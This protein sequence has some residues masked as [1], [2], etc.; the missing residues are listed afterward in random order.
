MS[1]NLIAK[2][3]SSQEKI[4]QDFHTEKEYTKGSALKNEPF[5][6]C[7]SYRLADKTDYVPLSISAECDG[8]PISIY[9]IGYVPIVHGQSAI[10]DVGSE[11]RGSGMYPDMLLPRKATP[12]IIATGCTDGRIPFF[13]EDEKNIV[14][15]TFDTTQGIWFV[16][17]EDCREIEAKSYD[18]VIKA[19]SMNTNEVL[20]EK[21]FT[22]EI[23]DALLPET[24]VKYTNWFHYDCLADVY[25]IEI[26]SEEYFEILEDYLKHAATN[27]MNMLLIP[28]FTPALDTYVGAERKTAQLVKIMVN[29]GEY[30]FDLS[31]LERFMLLADKCGIKY[32]EHTHLFS[33]WGAGHCPNIYAN[34]DGEYKRIFGWETDS[35]AGEY[36]RFLE[37]YIPKY[38]DLAKKLGFSERLF[39]HISDEPTAD[40]EESYGKAVETVKGLFD[41]YMSGDALSQYEF[42]EKG[43]VKTPIVSVSRV[44]EFFEKTKD[45]WIYYT[46]GYYE[47]SGLNTCMNRVITS[48]PPRTRVLGLQ[49][50]R[51]KAN[52]FLHWAYNYYYDRMSKGVFDPKSDP[53]GYKQLPGA[54][55]LIYPATDR[56]AISSLRE[57]YMREGLSD[58]RALKLL[59]SYIGYEDVMEIANN[60]FGQDVDIHTIPSANQMIEFRALINNELKKYI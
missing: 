49:M 18:I 48:K 39:F 33:Q 25:N 31:L 24:D 34:V 38:L 7:L 23:I 41:D 29:N 5:S 19:K 12:T 55:F 6:F 17:N 52:G 45:L 8:L 27:G 13:E 20:A 26:F 3:V 4:F 16:V 14:N 28:A 47:G 60:Y 53:C 40:V 36:R 58:Y 57:K 50:F 22:L 44:E 37:A 30:S 56:K 1:E 59:E 32:F 51:Y 9:K 35:A 2:L 10:A 15:A 46:G 11:E 42:C 21:T 43:F 54:S